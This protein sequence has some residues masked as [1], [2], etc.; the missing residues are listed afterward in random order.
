MSYK[1]RSIKI[2]TISTLL[3]LIFTLEPKGQFFTLPPLPPDYKFGNILINRTSEKNNVKPATF[4]HWI[5]RQKH[6]CRVCHFELEF[7]FQVNTTEITEA[8]NKA[9]MY[10]GASGCHDGKTVF[11]H[12]RPHCEK[13]HNGNITYGKEKF[14]ELS[15]LPKAK[16]G[17]GIDWVKAMDKD[18][19]KPAHYL[20][21]MPLP[22]EG[23]TFNKI[24]L[25]E[26]EMF[27]IPPAIFPHN[28]HIQW[29]DCNN[30]HPDV[31]TVKKK[32]TQHFSMEKILQKKFCGVCHLNVAFPMDH[33]NRC[34]PLMSDYWG[35]Y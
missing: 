14:S 6:T 20:M 24:L 17:N 26:A 32:E 1:S 22:L 3:L 29:L 5:H 12:D 8:A 13:C 35:K 7:N 28:P 33:C 25:L 16:F 34:H 30:C 4:S 10:C 18:M 9:G 21:I 23:F 31:F 11:G 27:G 15:G 19:I 2:V